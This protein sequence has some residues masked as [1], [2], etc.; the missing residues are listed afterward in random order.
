MIAYDVAY[1]FL[2][3]IEHNDE[4]RLVSMGEATGVSQKIRAQ[5][6]VQVTEHIW[7]IRRDSPPRAI[8]PWNFIADLDGTVKSHAV[9]DVEGESSGMYPPHYR[10]PPTSITSMKRPEQI[11]RQERFAF[12]SL[13]YGIWLCKKPFEWL[14]GEE[15][16]QRYRNA[17]LPEDVR[18]LPSPLFVAVL[19]NW[20]VEL[21]N[22]SMWQLLT[23]RENCLT[24]AV[25]GLHNR[26]ESYMRAH[27][28]RF[29]LQA[30]GAL[31]GTAAVLTPAI[32][33]VVGFGALGPVAG[34]AAAGW[35]GSIGAVQAGSVFAW[36][37]SAAMGGAAVNGIIA[38]GAAGGG[39][40]AL[41]T[42]GAVGQ[43]DEAEV[44]LKTFR[45]VYRKG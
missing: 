24:M 34:S 2:V 32:L 39:V 16:Q 13:L 14:S 7:G 38:T 29:A 40:V 15:V 28:Y 44:L 9:L 3:R 6:I 22:S 36:C 1:N 11:M 31:V 5:W 21:E 19:S 18:D 27:P 35:Q 43:D 25:N 17:H 23:N 33:G 30:A 8:R 4:V 42:A 12:A 45:E 41:A 10:I 26:V 37:Q 20:S